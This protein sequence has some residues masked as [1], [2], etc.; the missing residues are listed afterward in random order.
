MKH[1]VDLFEKKSKRY[2][3]AKKTKNGPDAK[4]TLL[5]SVRV[6]GGSRWSIGVVLASVSLKSVAW[7]FHD[8]DF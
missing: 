1:R 4:N 7:V 2:I 3:F 6:A 5:I 8:M